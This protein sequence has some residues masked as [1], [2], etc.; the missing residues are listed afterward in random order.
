MSLRIDDRVAIV[1][2]S[3]RGIGRATAR[4]LALQGA[5]VVVSDLDSSF[6]QET[7]EAIKATGGRAHALHGDVSVPDFPSQ[8]VRTALEIFG[9]LDI[10]VNN[11]GFTWDGTLHKLDRSL[12]HHPSCGALPSRHGKA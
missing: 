6:A 1:T 7:V 10:L 9:G 12:S 4:L 5:R 3:G 11:A 2:G 8:L